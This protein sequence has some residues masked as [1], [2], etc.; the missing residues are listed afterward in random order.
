MFVGNLKKILVSKNDA[1]GHDTSRTV[2]LRKMNHMTDVFCKILPKII[3]I[4]S[5]KKSLLE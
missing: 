1:F 2:I 5:V 3:E 4:I